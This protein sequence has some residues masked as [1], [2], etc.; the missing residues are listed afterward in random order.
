MSRKPLPAQTLYLLWSGTLSFA[1]S[2]IFTLMAVYYV[3]EVHLNPLQ[4]VLVGTV[5]EGTIFL[6]EVPTGVLADTYSRRLSVIVGTCLLGLGPAIEAITPAFGA[7]LAGEVVRG[8]GYTF[9]SGAMD[10]WLAG[11]VG[12]EQVGRIYLRGAQVD[13]FASL[14]GIPCSV[15]LAGAGLRIPVL[16]GSGVIVAMAACLALFMAETGFQPLPRDERGSWR[17]MGNTT[18][19]GMRAIR[20]RPILV[21]F[22]IIAVL[23]G[24]SSEG[25]DRLWEAHLLQDVHLPLFGAL[26]PTAWFGLIR[27][28]TAL[29]SI[30]VIEVVRRKVDAG[31]ERVMAQV[32]VVGTLLQSVSM[33][34]FAV[35]GSF[36]AALACYWSAAICRGISE[37]LRSTWLV[38]HVAPQV[39]ATVLS[40]VSQADAIGQTALGPAIGWI[41][42]VRGLRTALTVA[43]SLLLPALPL[44]ARAGRQGES[45]DAS[46]GKFIKG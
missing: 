42:T 16:V 3:A 43:G 2:V 36:A 15:L 23:F 18:R 12:E 46:A 4:L 39:R 44:F 30:G 21:T 7:V 14:V 17:T 26:R 13:R 1:L 41:G 27:M 20:S 34:G 5:L 22:L 28:G 32:L 10:A 38:R 6:F 24:M 35:A 11:E 25:Y 9:T 19:E 29:L 33:V 40:T 45:V 8:F 37:P 31:R